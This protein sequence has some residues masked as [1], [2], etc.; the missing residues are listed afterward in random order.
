MLS[1]GF[2]IS[3]KLKFLPIFSADHQ[4]SRGAAI[5]GGIYGHQDS[6]RHQQS[7]GAAIEGGIY[8][9]QNSAR[10]VR[11]TVFLKNVSIF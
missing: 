6:A 9:D 5:E 1:F 3:K 2:F 11:V 4:Q 7:R 8:D 10:L